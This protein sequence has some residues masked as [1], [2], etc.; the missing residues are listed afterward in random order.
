MNFLI[1]SNKNKLSIITKKSR[2]AEDE[3]NSSTKKVNKH[4]LY[5]YKKL[6]NR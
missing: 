6:S 1:L 4:K 3:N 2:G 5:P